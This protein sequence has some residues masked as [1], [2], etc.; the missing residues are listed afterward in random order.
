MTEFFSDNVSNIRF[1]AFDTETTGVSTSSDQIVEIAAIAFDEEFEHRRFQTLVKPSIPI[2]SSALRIHGI[3]DD[4]VVCAPRA[5]EALPR[6]FEFLSWTG[7]P[8]VLVA[9]NANF[10]VGMVYGEARR[11]DRALEGCE[12]VI[13]SCMLAKN[14]LPEL[15]SHALAALASHFKIVNDRFHRALDDVIVLQ[16][17]FLNLL[18]LA[19]DRLALGDAFTLEHLVNLCGGYFVLDPRDRK[20]KKHCFFLPPRIQAL[21]KLCGSA[22]KVAIIY[23][24]EG[25]YRYVTP[26]T[27]KARAGRVYLEAFCH[28]DNIKKTFRADKILRIGRTEHYPEGE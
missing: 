21:E 19:A 4:M 10:D 28:R 14:L 5:A 6:F 22:V 11:M 7:S 13:D 8:R 20:T 25:D 16:K 9:H 12:I 24:T 1:V 27:I 3:S 23:E 26:I 15:S 18:S 17:V 2:P